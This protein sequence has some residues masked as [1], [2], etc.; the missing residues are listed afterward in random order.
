MGLLG[1]IY[2]TIVTELWPLNLHLN[3]ISAQYLEDK[4]TEIHPIM[5]PH[6]RVG[7]HTVFPCASVR[8]SGRL[9]V[10]PSQNR[11]RSTA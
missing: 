9:S 5:S 4:L 2:R 10:S 1:I 7:R 6:I 11:V 3:F 8:P